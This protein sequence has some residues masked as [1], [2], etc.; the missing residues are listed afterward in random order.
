MPPDHSSSEWFL[1]ARLKIRHLRLFVALDK[2]RAMGR[3]AEA[4]AL[5]Q[6][7]ASRMLADVERSLGLTLFERLPRGMTPT[8]YGEVMVR[9][10]RS[11]LTE[12]DRTG[13]EVLALQQG[14]WLAAI[15]STSAPG[16]SLI[17]AAI[18]AARARRPDLRISVQVDPSER[19]IAKVLDGELDLA[20]CRIPQGAEANALLYR[21]IAGE[22][23]N[24]IC[25]AGWGRPPGTALRLA[26]LVDDEWVLHPPGSVIR[27]AAEDA[28]RAEGATVPL[29]LVDTTSFALT[30]A[31]LQQTAAL[32]IVPR[33]VARL[34]VALGSI[35]I[36]PV[37]IPVSISPVGLIRS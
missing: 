11:V 12:L 13:K 17:I 24:V 29:R 2:H 37:S 6:P 30:L 36:L 25:G 9:R 35:H 26:D 31:L 7:A 8:V 18:R 5:T 16:V 32:A 27:Q 33:S 22:K 15:G 34:Y 23:L 4:V 10:A 20:I 1:E 3:A 14:R 19:L 28:F 21:E